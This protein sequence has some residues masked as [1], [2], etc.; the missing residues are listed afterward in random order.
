M[1]HSGMGKWREWLFFSRLSV[2]SVAVRG[3]LAR[4]S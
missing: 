2:M 1:E 3:S 4:P